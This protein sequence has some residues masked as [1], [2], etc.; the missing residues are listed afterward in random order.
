MSCLPVLMDSLT[1]I[2][3]QWT[4]FAYRGILMGIPLGVSR[5]DGLAKSVTD[6]YLGRW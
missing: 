2:R 6:P 3:H 5:Y 4:R 1:D